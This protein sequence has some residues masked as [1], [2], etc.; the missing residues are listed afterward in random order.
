MWSWD[1]IRAHRELCKKYKD[2]YKSKL[3]TNKPG[4][5]LIADLEVCID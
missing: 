2:L 4:S 1:V 5:Q 3:L